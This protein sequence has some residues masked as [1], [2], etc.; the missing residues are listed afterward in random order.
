M[1]RP[2]LAQCFGA[3]AR[4]AARRRQGCR[5]PLIP[6]KVV[7]RRRQDTRNSRF[8][9][10]RPPCCILP[11]RAFWHPQ[12]LNV[13]Q[14]FGMVLAGETIRILPIA[15]FFGAPRPSAARRGHNR[16]AI[17]PRAGRFLTISQLFAARS[18]APPRVTQPINRNLI[19]DQSPAVG[20]QALRRPGYPAERSS[21]RAWNPQLLS[22]FRPPA[23]GPKYTGS[24]TWRGPSRTDT[25]SAFIN[26]MARRSAQIH[27]ET[28]S[29]AGPLAPHRSYSQFLSM[30]WV[31]GRFQS[32]GGPT[33]MNENRSEPKLL[34]TLLNPIKLLAR[35]VAPATATRQ[36]AKPFSI[37]RHLRKTVSTEVARSISGC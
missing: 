6:C 21:T 26:V 28:R 7:L 12:D 10:L 15:R 8:D 24:T 25:F 4:R 1:A 27:P 3:R 20:V 22:M 14:C 31:A 19:L 11:G 16:S 34:S 17:N 18:S 30:S 35:W 37:L 13:Y 29:R 36:R 23:R 9:S 5:P 32:T 33:Q 2:K